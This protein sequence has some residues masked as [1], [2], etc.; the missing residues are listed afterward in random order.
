MSKIKELFLQENTSFEHYCKEIDMIN[1]A[2][3]KFMMIISIIIFSVLLFISFTIKSFSELSL[4]Y[5]VLLIFSILLIIIFHKRPQHEVLLVGIYIFFCLYVGIGIYLNAI[6]SPDS[7][8]ASIIGILSIIPLT[9]VDKSWRISTMMILFY[10]LF[11]LSSFLTKE[12]SLV[13]DDSITGAIFTIAGLMLGRYTR[14]I[15]LDNIANQHRLKL[16]S[17]T[18][19]LTRLYNRRKLKGVI[20]EREDHISGIMMLDIDFFK[21]YND[22]YGHQ[23]GDACLEEFGAC[24]QR[25]ARL[26]QL[27]AFRY[28]GEEFILLSEEYSYDELYMIA[29]EL[30]KEI[31]RLHIP[32]KNSPFGVITVSIGVSERN[33]CHIANISELI[34]LADKALYQGKRNGRN[35]VIGYSMDKSNM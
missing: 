16:L 19:A 8:G 33:V 29:N 5:G 6:E 1:Y 2:M 26:Y 3:F 21:Q 18:D 13:L 4:S 9:I 20:K 15:K 17:D 23:L 7:Q 11:V 28:G 31:K 27:K 10:I 22:E 34:N 25:I 30:R 14:N 32:F 12:V 24:L 35:I